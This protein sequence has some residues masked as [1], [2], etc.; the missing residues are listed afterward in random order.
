VNASD[1]ERL[2]RRA[3]DALY[4]SARQPKEIVWMSG[5]HVHGD[6]E[7]IQRLVEIVMR[8]VRADAGDSTARAAD[9]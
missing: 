8:R 9:Q 5:R 7:T 3:V 4:A 2:P 1:D 6:K